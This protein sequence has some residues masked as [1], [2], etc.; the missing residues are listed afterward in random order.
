MVREI[1]VQSQVGSYQRLKKW[2][3][4]P[5]CLTFSIIRYVSRI[6][7]SNPGEGVVHSPVPRCRSYW[8]RS[9]RVALNYGRQL[10]FLFYLEPLQE[11]SLRVRVDQKEMLRKW[12]LKFP[13]PQDQSLTIR[14]SL[15]L[16]WRKNIYFREQ[17]EIAQLY[18]LSMGW[19]CTCISPY[20]TVF[21]QKLMFKVI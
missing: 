5:P 14:Y 20:D 1:G 8:K 4:I 15:M 11:Q 17:D 12:Y 3:L 21:H 7:W 6:K 18:I 2:L 13:K 16:Y 10:Y 9:L 19:Y